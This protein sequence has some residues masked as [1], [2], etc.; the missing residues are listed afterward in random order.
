MSTCPKCQQ[1]VDAQAI[2]CPF[3]RTTLKAYGHPGIPLY[4]AAKDE[5]L[6]DR[7]TYHEDDSCTY[8]KRPYATNCTLFHDKSE[9][10]VVD[11]TITLT[12][13]NPLKKIQRW[14]YR[15]RGLLFVLGLIGISVAI[16]LSK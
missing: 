9:P 16:A 3:C 2:E 6:C 13:N 10:L 7:C 12:P 15:N 4:Q 1:S 11:E 8:A 5:Y 14:C